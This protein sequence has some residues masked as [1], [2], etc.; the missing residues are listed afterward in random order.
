MLRVR[1]KTIP[2]HLMSKMKLSL[3][4]DQPL[5][6]TVMVSCFFYTRKAAILSQEHVQ[7]LAKEGLFLF[8]K[9][10]LINM[11]YLWLR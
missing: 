7:L 4:R 5:D 10:C 1:E 8:M 6:L 11:E 3:K 2:E 9:Q